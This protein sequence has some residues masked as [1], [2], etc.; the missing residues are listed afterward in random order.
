MLCDYLVVEIP[1]IELNDILHLIFYLLRKKYWT[2]VVRGRIIGLC[3]IFV[4][5]Y[6][7]NKV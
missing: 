7:K 4:Q 2:K 5:Y 6:P 1:T 3:M